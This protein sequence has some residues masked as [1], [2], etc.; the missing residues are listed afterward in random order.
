MANRFIVIRPKKGVN[1]KL[2]FSAIRKGL[3]ETAELTEKQFAK[4]T[5]T[6]AKPVKFKKVLK[7]V[8]SPFRALITTD[9]FIY[10]MVNDGTKDHVITPT[11]AHGLLVFPAV[12]RPKTTPRLISSKAGFKSKKMIFVRGPIKVKG[13]KA[14][15]FDKT[16]A[17]WLLPKFKKI[18]QKE[19]DKA[20]RASGMLMRK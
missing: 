1:K 8:S 10:K 7:T 20:V 11:K 15:E 6:W 18:M 12:S 4:T 5:R 14:R 17:K 16:I 9:N 13:I 19:L 2:F 3:D